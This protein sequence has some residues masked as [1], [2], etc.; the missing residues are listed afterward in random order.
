M[1]GTN[2]C[3]STRVPEALSGRVFPEITVVAADVGLLV[4]ET[5]MDLPEVT[6]TLFEPPLPQELYQGGVLL[7]RGAL[8]ILEPDRRPGEVVESLLEVLH[9]VQ[10]ERVLRQCQVDAVEEE[11]TYQRQSV[12]LLGMQRKGKEGEVSQL[13]YSFHEVNFSLNKRKG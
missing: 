13:I 4:G 2:F 8:P 1:R 7:D 5:P 11:V 12:V 6:G 3:P 10:Q 9:Q